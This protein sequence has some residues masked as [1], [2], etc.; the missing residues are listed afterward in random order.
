MLI[1]CNYMFL[2]RN[3]S[4]EVLSYLQYLKSFQHVEI[5]KSGWLQLQT[6]RAVELRRISKCFNMQ[7][8]CQTFKKTFQE[9]LTWCRVINRIHNSWSFLSILSHS[10]INFWFNWLGKPRQLNQ[11]LIVSCDKMDKNDHSW[12]ILYLALD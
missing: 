11:K 9:P 3:H 2:W 10:T 6:T 1:F 7:K 8:T 12:C 5:S 4:L